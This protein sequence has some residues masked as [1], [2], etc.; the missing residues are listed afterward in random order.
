M[1]VLREPDA[2]PIP[3]Y[4]LIEPLGSGGFGEV[5]KCEAPGGLFKAIKFVFGNLNS[6]DIDGARAEQELQ[7]LNRVK[8]IRHP[9]ILGMDRIEVFDGELVIVMELADKNLHDHYVECQSAGLVGVP[10]DDLLRYLRDA[11]EAL[12]FMCEKHEL[13]HLDIKPRNLFLVSDR[14]KVA[15]FGLV[16]HLERTGGSGLLSGVTP[17]YA[18]PETFSGKISQRTD[19][20]SLSIV[21]QELLTSQRPFAGKNA[22]QLAQQH[23]HEPPELRPLP[24]A[25]RGIVARALSKDPSE[26]F[27]SC[28]AFV[29]ALY[30]ARAA[31]PAGPAAR[32]PSGNRPKSMADTMEDI[33]LE[34]VFHDDS[35]PVALA[36][37][38]DVIDLDAVEHTL[39]PEEASELGLTAALPQTGILRPTLVIGLGSLGRRALTELRCRLLDRFG[40]LAKLPL[41]RYLYID[42]D[43]EALVQAQRGASEVALTASEVYHLPLQ[44]VAHYRRR[45][46]DQISDWLPREKLYA[47]PRSLQTQGS[48]ALGRL[49]YCDNYMR[50]LSRVKR[51][52][53][54]ASHPDALYQS[55]VDTGLALRDATP[56]V[57]VLASATGGASGY[58]IDLAYTIRRLFRQSRQEEARITALLF[59][60]APDDPATPPA[61][62]ANLYG[63][64]T[65]IN[66]YTEGVTAFNAQ[67]GTDG[68]RQ[69]EQGPPYDAVYLLPQRER[70]PDARRDVVAHAGSYLFHELITPLGPRLERIRQTTPTAGAWGTPLGTFRC[71]G[72]HAVWFPRGLLLRLAARR[73]VGTLLEQ[74]ASDEAVSHQLSAISQKE[75]QSRLFSSVWLTADSCELRASSVEA[76]CARVLAD[77][78]LQ[79]GALTLRLEE[80]ASRYLDS[81]SPGQALAKLMA[82]LEEQCWQ[83][84]GPDDAGAWASSALA[85]VREWLGSGVQGTT[86]GLTVGL[87]NRKSRLNRALENACSQLAEEWDRKLTDVATSL[88]DLPGPR[89]TLAEAALSRLLEHALHAAQDQAL[90]LKERAEQTMAAQSQLDEALQ[91]CSRG[92]FRLFSWRPQRPLRVFL[93]RLAAFARQC[94]AEDTACAVQQFYSALAA[95]LRDRLRDL[96]LLRQRLRQVQQMLVSPLDLLDDGYQLSAMS[97]QP[98]KNDD[99]LDDGNGDTSPTP[100]ASLTSFWEVTRVSATG[101]VVLPE[102]ETDLD[103]AAARFV[104]TLTAEHWGLV[105]QTLSDEVLGPRG[106]LT[107]ACFASNDLPRFLLNPLVDRAAACLSQ[108]L[109]VTDVAQVERGGAD[110]NPEVLTRRLQASLDSATPLVSPVATASGGVS[111]SRGKK[112]SKALAVMGAN[113][114]P[115]P[116]PASVRPLEDSRQT[117]RRGDEPRSSR[118]ENGAGNAPAEGGSLAR[119][120]WLLIPASEAGK[121]YGEQARQQLPGVHLVRVPGQADLMFCQEQNGLNPDELERLISPCREA[122]QEASTQP[123]SSPHSRFD[124]RDWVPLDP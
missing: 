5:W 18:P 122:Y 9:F 84:G 54:A 43:R 4:R 1:S 50:L 66:H 21:Y 90:L 42:T 111:R 48:R 33:Q 62:L 83:Y 123:V 20:Y 93:D 79:P 78:D 40:D 100:M 41:L 23:L 12:D 114:P 101:R 118:Q 14:V 75:K 97:Y 10:R 99:F 65:E 6:L 119:E 2:E 15:D 103:R 64:L 29:R 98:E 37:G 39:R 63:T 82:G 116:A 32:N 121:A 27:P 104:S 69:V 52:L 124:T 38:P 74:W 115:Q 30:N 73:V 105:D 96:S 56:R 11:A 109:P 110:E 80:A 58:L 57:V 71:F 112:D 24:E 61:E 108:Y 45:Q 86:A 34:Q 77:P 3:G 36:D 13:Q 92:G 81:L 47:L 95:R 94:L 25:D 8:E 89:V 102:G 26:R 51:E 85:R 72:T 17:L 106:G 91:N 117:G 88:M 87:A 53:A 7:A 70:S 35:E 107:Q 46:L 19:Q 16:K 120:A 55:V 76:A 68:Q 22:R 59:C 60:G 113:G 49:A 31:R 67:Y 28:L 44:P